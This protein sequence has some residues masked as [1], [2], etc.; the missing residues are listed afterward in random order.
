MVD[1]K[2][3]NGGGKRGEYGGLWRVAD[4]SFDAYGLRFRFVEELADVGKK[5]KWQEQRKRTR[6][7]K[8]SY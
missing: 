2:R 6:R 3:K 7:G 4:L 8:G 1:R 5:H